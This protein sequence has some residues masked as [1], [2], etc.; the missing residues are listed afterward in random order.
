[1]I[2][3]FDSKGLLPKGVH[4][5]NWQE[6]VNRFGSNRHRRELLRGLK[7]ALDLPRDAGCR[8]VYL[9]GSFVTDRE[10]PNDID[11]LGHRW[12]ESDVA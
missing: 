8:R 11:A 2:P 9:D 12:R 1:M 4:R 10:F 5:A 3:E 6:T 7:E